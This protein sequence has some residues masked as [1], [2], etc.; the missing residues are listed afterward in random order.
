MKRPRCGKLLRR[1]QVACNRPSNHRG[2]CCVIDA[3]AKSKH[4]KAWRAS[5]PHYAAEWYIA[6]ADSVK[7]TGAAWVRANPDRKRT[8][9]AAWAARN[10]NRKRAIDVASRQRRRIPRL[11]SGRRRE[12]VRRALKKGATAVSFTSSEYAARMASFDNACYY[13]ALLGIW[14]PHECDD[15]VFPL[16]PRRGHKAGPHTLRNLVPSCNKH[17][18]K[19]SNKSPTDFINQILGAP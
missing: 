5:N 3:T 4:A 16:S 19:K 13:C 15:H 1:L 8:N 17:N 2:W 6:N 18:H 12:Q 7:A 11:A 14:G 9:G 10:P